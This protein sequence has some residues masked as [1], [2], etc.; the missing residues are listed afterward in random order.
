MGRLR[1]P[2]GVLM[3]T[4][5]MLP[6]EP[7]CVSKMTPVGHWSGVDWSYPLVRRRG[8]QVG[9]WVGVVAI[10]G[11]ASNP[12]GNLQTTGSRIAEAAA[13]TVANWKSVT[14]NVSQINWW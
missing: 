8:F 14:F 3:V 4:M 2:L 7:G 9:N 10:A 13:D 6:S 1:T 11:A 5:L 12:G